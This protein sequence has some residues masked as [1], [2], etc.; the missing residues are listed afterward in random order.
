[1]NKTDWHTK[2]DLKGIHRVAGADVC[3][4]VGAIRV[5]S[6]LL[7]LQFNHDAD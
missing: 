2:L 1:M 7:N 3:R 4:D 5:E 6:L